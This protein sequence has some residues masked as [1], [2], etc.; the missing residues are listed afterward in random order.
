MRFVVL[1]T[2]KQQATAM[3]F[4]TR[5]LFVR[6]RT[7]LINALRAHLAEQGF[8]AP[9]GIASPD[10][11][12]GI[13]EDDS[14]LELLVVETARIYLEQ[15]DLL[16]SRIS[17]LEKVLKAKAQQTINTARQMSMPGA[18]QSRPWR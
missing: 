2:E 11:L 7:Q 17:S 15:I 1:K 10:A 18:G 14:G 13:V 5:D 6:Q 4:R 12:R 3:I 9:Q 16:T 8:I